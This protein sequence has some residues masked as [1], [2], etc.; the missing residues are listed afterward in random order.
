[1]KVAGANRNIRRET[2]ETPDF[3]DAIAAFGLPIK[4]I[5]DSIATA[6]TQMPRNVKAIATRGKNIE[7]PQVQI[8]SVGLSTP[9]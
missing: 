9:H 2:N 7:P 4:R 8:L 5:Q 1:M 3:G 6:K